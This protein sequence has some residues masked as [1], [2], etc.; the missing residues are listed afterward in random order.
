[1]LRIDTYAIASAIRDM[2]ERRYPKRVYNE[3]GM[4]PVNVD[5]LV[6]T[7]KR[8]RQ[9]VTTAFTYGNLKSIMNEYTAK[10]K[11]RKMFSKVEEVEIAKIVISLDN[12]QLS[13]F[14][15]S[16]PKQIVLYAASDDILKFDVLITTDES[17]QI[18]D[19][20]KFI[21]DNDIFVHNFIAFL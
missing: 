4:M 14:S 6:N 2:R 8:N 21:L 3:I 11:E 20:G 13:F 5:R 12:Q 15:L 10:F 19:L 7:Y 1:M 17:N 9:S 16:N 18:V